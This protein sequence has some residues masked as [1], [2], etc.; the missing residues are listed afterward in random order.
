MPVQPPAADQGAAPRRGERGR[1]SDRGGGLAARARRQP[2]VA[3]ARSA[4][5]PTGA[6]G[7]AVGRPRASLPK[8]PA[9]DRRRADAAAGAGRRPPGGPRDPHARPRARAD[10]APAATATRVVV[11]GSGFI[12]CEIA[13]SLQTARPPGDAGLRRA[14]AQRGT[15]RRR[16]GRADSPLARARKASAS[17]SER[18][19]RRSR[20][21]TACSRCGPGRCARRRDVVVMAAGVAPRGEL[22]AGAGLELDGGAVP[23][24]PRCAPRRP[25]CY[26]AGDVALRRQQ[27]RR[28]P[29]CASSTGA[30]RSARA[31]SP[32]AAPPGTTRAGTRSPGSGRRSAT[33]R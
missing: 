6:R 29:R 23:S 27:P 18:R 12:G 3:A 28:A 4:S 11:I 5:T 22:A 26:A 20:S 25:A 13:A 14:G 8:L 33:A 15:A 16:G 24:T 2:G 17:G 30:T 19:S 21:A 10:P 31:R 9:R 1:A 32:A 7:G